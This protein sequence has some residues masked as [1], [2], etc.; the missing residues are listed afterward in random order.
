MI[1][2]LY[3]HPFGD[4]IMVVGIDGHKVHTG[5]LLPQVNPGSIVVSSDRLGLKYPPIIVG[6]L[7]R[8][9]LYA[10]RHFN[11]ELPIRRVRVN[12][13]L[14][15]DVEPHSVDVKYPGDV[16]PLARHDAARQ[17]LRLHAGPYW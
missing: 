12:T 6:D 3:D 2:L 7:D 14:P 5:R 17:D 4:G 8:G 15:V 10:L 1:P 13:D 16:L 11:V 9:H